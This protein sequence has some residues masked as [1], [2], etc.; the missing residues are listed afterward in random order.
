MSTRLINSTEKNTFCGTRR[1]STKFI[2][3]NQFC[4]SF[5]WA[6]HNSIRIYAEELLASK[7]TAKLEDHAF[8]TAN[9]CLFTIFISS[10]HIW[11][12]SQFARWGRA[13]LSWQSPFITKWKIIKSVNSSSLSRTGCYDTDPKFIFWSTILPST[14]GSS[15]FVF[16]LLDYTSTQTLA[17]HLS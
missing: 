1:F 8:S 5:F 17:F 11:K 6:T 16:D 7:A 10:L 13:M 3:A 9:D 15:H 12:P 14:L 4:L 2:T